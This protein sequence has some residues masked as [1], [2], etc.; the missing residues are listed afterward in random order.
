MPASTPPAA[1]RLTG[2]LFL[3]L[4][5]STGC[6]G[7]ATDPDDDD[8]ASGAIHVTVSTT[9]AD[10]DPDGYVAILDGT[11]PTLP[12]P[13][14]GSADF[15]NVAVGGHTMTLSGVQS[16]CGVDG[17]FRSVTVTDG[18]TAT[19][20][21]TVTCAGPP[22]TV[23][24]IRVIT[25]T[26]GPNPDPDG[27]QFAIDSGPAQ[28][29]GSTSTATV[30]D[31]GVGD[32][33]VVL[34]GVAPNCGLASGRL[35]GAPVAGGYTTDAI[36]TVT[37]YALGPSP[38]QS[39]V[40]VDPASITIGFP[41]QIHLSM[42]IITVTVLDASGTPLQ[43]IEVTLNAT[44]SGNTIYPWPAFDA[45]TTDAK[46]MAKFALSSTVPEAK[47]ITASANGV[48]LEQTALVTVV[49]SRSFIGVARADPE[50]SVSGETVVVTVGV[51]GERG[52][53]P[54]G[55]TVA[56]YSNL[57]PDAGCDAAPVNSEGVA[58]CEMSLSIVSTHLLHATYSGDS[59]F[60]PS[61]STQ[62]LEHVVIAP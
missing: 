33:T 1:F 31:I 21:F 44:G 7:D 37:C 48:E 45:G 28:A 61:S 38:A 25:S 24:S 56:V 18:A 5:S 32:H 47:T 8:P 36:F 23:G 43:G 53:W 29:I 57:E 11:G 59:Q 15:S 14:T 55:G 27:Y 20:S 39:T 60:E 30:N 42:S 16:N 3:A 2:M 12:L 35:R 62:D 26:I 19:V 50:P 10:A 41:G 52:M 4:V 58:T 9:G 40:Q 49:K 51:G 46:G 22:Q 17:A 6:G 54:T 13:A 34:S